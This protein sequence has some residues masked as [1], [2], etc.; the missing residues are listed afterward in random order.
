MGMSQSGKTAN[1][2]CYLGKSNLP[3]V[4]SWIN[5]EHWGLYVFNNFLREETLPFPIMSNKRD[6]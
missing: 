2:A 4:I 3:N 1:V 6:S 5:K